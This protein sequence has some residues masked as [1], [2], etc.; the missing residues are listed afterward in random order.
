MDYRDLP[1]SICEHML[2]KAYGWS[3]EYISKI[4]PSKFQEHMSILIVFHRMNAIGSL[5]GLGQS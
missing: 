4:S 2:A 1:V 5:S 3:L